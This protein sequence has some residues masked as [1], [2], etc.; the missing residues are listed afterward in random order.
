M[1]RL[2]T[3]LVKEFEKQE[4]QLKKK[5][6]E[7]GSNI[8]YVSVSLIHEKVEHQAIYDRQLGKFCK[9]IYLMRIK[10]ITTAK[11]IILE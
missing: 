9:I 7:P 11:E 4:K 1:T 5:A 10:E 2:E 6:L 3:T 8:R